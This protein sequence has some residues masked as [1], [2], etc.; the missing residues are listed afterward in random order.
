MSKIN[1]N[2]TF[3]LTKNKKEKKLILQEDYSKTFS[4]SKQAIQPSSTLQDEN[5]KE[6]TNEDLAH[7]SLEELGETIRQTPSVE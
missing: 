6:N 7:I 1:C 5:Y 2:N 4:Y 3:T